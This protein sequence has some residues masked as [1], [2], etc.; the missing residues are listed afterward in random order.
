MEL[1]KTYRVTQSV[2]DFYA[3]ERRHLVNKV[4]TLATHKDRQVLIFGRG[5]FRPDEEPLWF[6]IRTVYGSYWYNRITSTVEN[7][8]SAFFIFTADAI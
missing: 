8:N 2:I 3:N 5:T 1:D 4:P 7:M 6:A